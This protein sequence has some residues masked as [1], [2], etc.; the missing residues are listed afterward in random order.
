MKLIAKVSD[1]AKAR[2]VL[3]AIEVLQ[4]NEVASSD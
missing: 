4:K 1:D 2:V 3:N